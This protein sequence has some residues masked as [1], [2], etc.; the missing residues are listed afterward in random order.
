MTEKDIT[1]DLAEKEK[2]LDW[3][4]DKNIY[5]ID[6]VGQIMRVYYK[7]PDILRDLVNEGGQFEQLSEVDTLE[8]DGDK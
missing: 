4:L 3:M 7:Y 2:I 1:N 8:R 5:D 6:K